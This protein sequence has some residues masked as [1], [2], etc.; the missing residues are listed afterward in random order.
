MRQLLI[1]LYKIARL[2]SIAWFKTKEE[3]EHGGNKDGK[4]TE[5]Q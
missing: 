2:I 5:K 4:K 3:F 1:P